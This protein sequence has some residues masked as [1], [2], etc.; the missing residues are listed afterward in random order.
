MEFTTDHYWLIG[1]ALTL[2]I[3]SMLCSLAEAAIV[4]INE[5]KVRHLSR[6]S[7]NDKGL[8]TLLKLAD[9]R[10]SILSM[11]ISLNTAVNI[12]G[13]M[14]IGTLS[15]AILDNLYYG[16]FTA[17]LTA[18]MLIYSE[19]KPKVYAAKHSEKIAR[20]FA[21]PLLILQRIL[22]P[23]MGIIDGLA[24]NTHH[25][26]EPIELAEVHSIIHSAVHDGAIGKN[27][28]LLIENLFTLRKQ[29]VS[30][31]MIPHQEIDT[32][33]AD[34]L[35]HDIKDKILN[36]KHHRIVV[37]N[38]QDKPVGVVNKDDLLEALVES[39]VNRPVAYFLQYIQPVNTSAKLSTLLLT[40]YKSETHLAVIFD[41]ENTMKGVISAYD[42]ISYLLNKPNHQIIEKNE[43]ELS[44]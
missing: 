36:C 33:R 6:Q 42:I 12:G 32:L 37:V 19:I 28:A 31:L 1:S 2:V 21:K 3:L 40:L 13:S 22:R 26:S 34:E 18:T 4:G 14:F 41:E 29:R 20:L 16:I 30:D 9:K 15:T 5:I 43:A 23:V 35:I 8:Q 11:I 24:N 38:P 7:P 44:E 39:D 27:E 25:T 10:I 17:A